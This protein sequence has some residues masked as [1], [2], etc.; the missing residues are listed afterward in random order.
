MPFQRPNN[1]FY[2]ISSVTGFGFTIFSAI[3]FPINSLD[4]SAVLWINFSK[5]V[6]EVYSRVFFPYLSDRQKIHALWHLLTYHFYLFISNV[7]INFYFKWS[8]ILICKCYH[9]SSKLVLQVF[10]NTKL[11]GSTLANNHKIY[12]TQKCIV[13]QTFAGIDYLLNYIGLKFFALYNIL[14]LNNSL[15]IF[16]K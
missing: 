15:I 4:A 14:F 10:K 9:I 6:F 2:S 5:D 8:T 13:P 1:Y 3:L 16:S 7:K 12:W 11:L